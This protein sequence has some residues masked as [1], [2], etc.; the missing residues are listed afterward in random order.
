M[1][2]F[3]T[4]KREKDHSFTVT[5]VSDV[6]VLIVF[7]RI[8]R[9]R[10]NV[11]EW[12]Q[13]LIWDFSFF[14][15]FVVVVVFCIKDQ[16]PIFTQNNENPWNRVERFKSES[17]FLIL[18]EF[19]FFWENFLG[20]FICM[21]LLK[22]NVNCQNLDLL[23]TVNTSCMNFYEFIFHK[24]FIIWRKQSEMYVDSLFYPSSG[25]PFLPIVTTYKLLFINPVY[26][27]LVDFC[28]FWL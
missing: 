22:I 18:L 23:E 19:S 13:R 27:L 25:N 9:F 11:F 3:Y 28:N 5:P 15:C 10:V 17:N 16:P 7:W 24:Q 12:I 1:T 26:F 2:L 20:R 14:F 8:L 6:R 21:S 4:P